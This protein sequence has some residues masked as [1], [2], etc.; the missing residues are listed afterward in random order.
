MMKILTGL[1][2]V[3]FSH[4][5]FAVDWKKY[6]CEHSRAGCLPPI[7]AGYSAVADLFVAKLPEIPNTA[8]GP[9]VQTKHF[10]AAISAG[11]GFTLIECTQ[12]IARA[13]INSC[14]FAEGPS[15]NELTIVTPL[16]FLGLLAKSETNL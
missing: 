1:L 6:G 8:T 16:E 2:L 5:A 14:A 3:S 12:K 15:A 10:G 13:I 7:H 9:Y 11:E 4:S